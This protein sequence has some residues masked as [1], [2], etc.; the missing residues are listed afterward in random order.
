MSHDELAH[1]PDLA[2]NPVPAESCADFS[3]I[4]TWMRHEARDEFLL[5]LRDLGP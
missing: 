3:F 5:S 4:G 1:S 2:P